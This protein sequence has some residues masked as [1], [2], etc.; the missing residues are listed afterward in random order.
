MKSLQAQFSFCQPLSNA[1]CCICI[2]ENTFPH[3]SI[4]CFGHLDQDMAFS[5]VNTSEKQAKYEKDKSIPFSLCGN[6]RGL[7]CLLYLVF[8]SA[9]S[10]N[11]GHDVLR[12]W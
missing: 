6:R 3:I 12:D 2:H 10:S 11:Y 4:T 8:L 7:G 5:N 9:D 1:L